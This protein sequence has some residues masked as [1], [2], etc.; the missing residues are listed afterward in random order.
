MNKL[1]LSGLALISV[2]LAACSEQPI[3]GVD[4]VAGRPLMNISAAASQTYCSTAAG[5]TSQGL[6][7][8]AKNSNWADPVTMGANTSVFVGPNSTSNVDFT[9]LGTYTYTVNLGL[10]AGSTVSSVSG[11]VLADNAVL[12]KAGA[13][14]L[15]DNRPPTP[16]VSNAPDFRT[17]PNFQTVGGV[18]FGGAVPSGTNVVTFQ[19]FNDDNPN[20]AAAN[21]N[22]SG[23]S[24][25]FTVNYTTQMAMRGCSPGYYKNHL[26]PTG[27]NKDALFASA[28]FT[29]VFPGMSFQDVLE[30]GGG[31]VTALGRHTVAAYYNALVFGSA[32]GLTPAQVVAEFNAA[33]AAGGSAVSE[34]SDR[35]ESMEDVNG[36]TCGNPTGKEAKRK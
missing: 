2:S 1:V 23:L 10:P 13:T 33:V 26:A 34:L 27:Q 12:V 17:S 14:T 25:C 9:R 6:F 5:A 31:G 21:F 18:A 22:P 7:A 3:T 19:V 32:Y 28:G 15:L 29:N 4:D 30:N 11:N 36:R 24:F 8:I 35:F 20:T 16:F